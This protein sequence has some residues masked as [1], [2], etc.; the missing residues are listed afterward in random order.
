MKKQDFSALIAG[1]RLFEDLNADVP[2]YE[3][4]FCE[5]HYRRSDR[6]LYKGKGGALGILARGKM[7]VGGKS[8]AH[9]AVIN[10]MAPGAV[11]GFASLYAAGGEDSRGAQKRFESDVWAKTDVAVLWLPEEALDRLMEE[12]PQIAR[13]IIALQ[14]EKIRFLNERIRA[15]SAPDACDKLLSYLSTLPQNEAGEVGLPCDMSALALRLGIGRASLYRA[16]RALKEKGVGR[17]EGKTFLF[18]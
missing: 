10:E 3:S 9:R 8:E 16:F 12:N 14:A 17:K 11:F 1:C 18:T 4:F 13:N 6:I 7:R 5:E 15:F 2:A